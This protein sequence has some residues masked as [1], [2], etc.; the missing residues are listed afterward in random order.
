VGTIRD[1]VSRDPWSDEEVEAES[2][3]PTRRSRFGPRLTI[4]ARNRAGTLIVLPTLLG[5][6]AFCIICAYILVYK[7]NDFTYGFAA[8]GCAIGVW[9][10]VQAILVLFWWLQ[11]RFRG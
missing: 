10:L 4:R 7:G 11:K 1:V 6:L 5:I 3:R 8:F 9:A 2:N